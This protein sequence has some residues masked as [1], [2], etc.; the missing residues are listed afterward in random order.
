M[1]RIIEYF[2]FPP[3]DGDLLIA[4]DLIIE[5]RLIREIKGVGLQIK[6]VRRWD[7]LE[8]DGDAKERKYAVHLLNTA[9]VD[10]LAEYSALPCILRPFCVR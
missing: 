7:W 2:A 4:G 9:F 8:C 1:A 6:R 5:V 10:C 3:R